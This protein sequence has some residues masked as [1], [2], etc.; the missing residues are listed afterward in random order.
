MAFL[1][2]EPS[3]KINWVNFNLTHLTMSLHSFKYAAQIK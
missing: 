1:G 2:I 3:G